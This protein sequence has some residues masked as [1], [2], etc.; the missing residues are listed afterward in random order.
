MAHGFEAKFNAVLEV[1]LPALTTLV[2]L[3]LLL[4][5]Y[6]IGQQNIQLRPSL[7]IYL[8]LLAIDFVTVIGGVALTIHLYCKWGFASKVIDNSNWITFYNNVILFLCLAVVRILIMRG[9]LQSDGTRVALTMIAIPWLITFLIITINNTT[10][11]PDYTKYPRPS[12][13]LSLLI[14]V[15]GISTLVM[16]L[17]IVAVTIYTRINLRAQASANLTA[18]LLFTNHFLCSLYP[19]TVNGYFL[20]LYFTGGDCK[21]PDNIYHW[22]NFFICT[23][24]GSDGLEL[25][26]LLV[27]AVGN[28][29]IMLL[30]KNSRTTLK[31]LWQRTICSGSSDEVNVFV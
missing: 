2:C 3:L 15:V 5:T 8:N 10:S 23:K 16:N 14:L 19:L 9:Y 18:I 26:L 21:D 11:F 28:N 13:I 7:R 22:S 1:L 25:V 30:H 31:I 20:C 27:Q 24:S 29:V 4:N 6:I 12:A 17:Y